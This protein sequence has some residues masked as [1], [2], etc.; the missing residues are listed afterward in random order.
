MQVF[1]A[2]LRFWFICI[3]VF[4]MTMTNVN[5]YLNSIQ[6]ANGKVKRD[7]NVGLNVLSS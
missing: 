6:A 4:V 1:T 7:A 2:P 5:A 3:S